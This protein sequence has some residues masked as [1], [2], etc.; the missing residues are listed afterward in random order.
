M[1]SAWEVRDARGGVSMLAWRILG[2]VAVLLAAVPSGWGQRY[3]V[4]EAVEP[5]DCSRATLDMKL[6]GE[7]RIRRADGI[8]PLKLEATGS[9]AFP[10]RVL[11]VGAA[12][13]AEKSARVYETAKASIT[14]GKDTN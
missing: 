4:A 10:E 13:L 9:H 6:S 5:G 11:G 7:M 12:G 3:P 1:E 2:T 8:L 14:V